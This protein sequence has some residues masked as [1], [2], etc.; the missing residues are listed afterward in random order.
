MDE[1]ITPD[2]E[3]LFNKIKDLESA[4]APSPSYHPGAGETSVETSGID[5]SDFA[6][7]FS[8]S[9]AVV[10]VNTG[11]VYLG[12]RLPVWV[13][14][15]ALTITV[16]NTWVF[17][18]YWFPVSGSSPYPAAILSSIT[19]PQITETY[20]EYPLQLWHVAS[21]GGLEIGSSVWTIKHVGDIILP[22]S[23][24]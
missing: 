9:G 16:D 24:A 22:G 1:S 17:V 14:S 6:F 11:Q 10:T 5:Y 12:T 19:D 8:I 21:G 2:N 4:S 20:I 18:R 15:K 23:F 3:F 7:G 13:P